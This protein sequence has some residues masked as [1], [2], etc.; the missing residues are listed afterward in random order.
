MSL[1]ISDPLLQHCIRKAKR[2]FFERW[3]T[4]P[5]RITLWGWNVDVVEAN[6]AGLFIIDPLG[7]TNPKLVY[8][9]SGDSVLGE[10][11]SL[12]INC[13]KEKWLETF[14]IAEECGSMDSIGGSDQ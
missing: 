4:R 1:A 8:A 14:L 6:L 12:A 11:T 3:G 9:S 2:L 5:D 13:D 10:Y 7:F